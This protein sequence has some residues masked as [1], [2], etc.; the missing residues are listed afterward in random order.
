MQELKG[1]VALVTGCSAP[2]GIGRAIAIRLAQNGASVVVSDVRGELNIDGNSFNKSE[3]LKQLVADIKAERGQAL[4]QIVD[5]TKQENIVA[6]LDNVKKS[7]GS[8]N[9]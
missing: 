9:N 6:G 5:V 8:V 3:L 2:R 4:D 7:L 1:K